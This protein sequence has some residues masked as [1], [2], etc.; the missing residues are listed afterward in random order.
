MKTL[1]RKLLLGFVAACLFAGPAL[2]EN[3]REIMAQVDDV[4]RNSYSSTIQKVKLSTCRYGRKGKKI[5][6]AE[7]PRVKVMESV[8][9]DTGVNGRDS[10]S[11][12]IILAPAR[13][14]G[15]GMLTYDY[16]DPDHDAD[17]WLYLSALGKVKRM[18]S[19]SDDDGESGSF[20]GTEFSIEDMENTNI[21]DFSYRIMKKTIYRKR[22]VWIIQSTPTAKKARKSKYSKIITWIDRERLITMKIQMYNRYGKPSKRMTLKSIKKIDGVWI[23]RKLTMNNLK[24]KRVTNMSLFSIA[25][26]IEVPDAFLT[27]RTLTDSA[28][29]ERE[30]AKLRRHLK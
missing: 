3:P 16:D 17:N 30:L 22:P 24:T 2:A 23:A 13:E 29:R 7:N 28:F 6:C 25:F 15:I 18:I 21:D 4:A 20:F 19:G 9:K 27:Q 26:N 14:K 10:Q 5:V 11:I 1:K 12:A 8:Q